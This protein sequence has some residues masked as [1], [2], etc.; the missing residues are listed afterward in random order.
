MSSDLKNSNLPIPPAVE[1]R[2]ESAYEAQ[3]LGDASGVEIF[4]TDG[5]VE[6]IPEARISLAM[7]GLFGRRSRRRTP[8]GQDDV[9]E[10]PYGGS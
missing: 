2:S 5:R 10:L 6:A 4:E 8:A 9:H 3:R 7:R 1:I